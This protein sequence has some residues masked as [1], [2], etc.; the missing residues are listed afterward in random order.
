MSLTFTSNKLTVF[1]F[2]ENFQIN[3]KWRLSPEWGLFSVWR[4]HPLFPVFNNWGSASLTVV[5]SEGVWAKYCSVNWSDDCSWCS[6]FLMKRSP[7][8]SCAITGF[9]GWCSKFSIKCSG[10]EMTG[11]GLWPVEHMFWRKSG[12][13]Q[14]KTKI[15]EVNRNLLFYIESLRSVKHGIVAIAKVLKLCLVIYTAHNYFGSQKKDSNILF[16]KI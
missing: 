9:E 3:Q 11:F 15:T 4:L 13:N 16:C 2:L 10:G 7:N 5:F 1:L 6:T 14:S 8:E 12:N